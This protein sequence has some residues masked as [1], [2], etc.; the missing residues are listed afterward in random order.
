MKYPEIFRVRQ[1]CNDPVVEDVAEEVE[2]QL[3]KLCMHQKIKAGDSVAISAGSRGISNIHLVLKAMVGHVK[4]LGGEPFLVPA[5]GSHGGGT[6]AGQQKILESYGIT[7][8]FC[9]CP[10]RATMETVVIA[11][12]AEGFDI[13]FDKYAHGADHILV[14]NRIK[15]HTQFFGTIE[16]GLHKMLLIGLGKHAGAKIYHRAIQDFSFDRILRSVTGEVLSRCPVLAGLA[17]V[18]NRRGETAHIEAVPADQ[19]SRREPRLLDLAN[20]WSPRLPFSSAHILI[21]D[22][23]GKNISGTGFDLRAVGRKYLPHMAAEEESPKVRMIAIRDLTDESLGNAEGL[24]LAEFCL[25]RVLEKR[26]THATRTN[27]LTSGHIFGSMIPL[28]YGTDRELL[29]AMLPQIGLSAPLDARLLWI[30][31]T[32]ILSEFEC[33]KAYLGEARARDDLEILTDPRPLPFGKDGNLPDERKLATTR[34][35]S[36]GQ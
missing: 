29:D 3:S 4:R 26:D 25:S 34:E 11:R 35:G 20:E 21:I 33:S 8:E 28:D 9:G 24:G 12:A 6:A 5:M 13:H 17:I 36:C 30:R 7:E 1:V 18:E 31:N 10:I 27:A 15:T 32:G 16:S 2:A 22:E 19:F 23:M 14:C